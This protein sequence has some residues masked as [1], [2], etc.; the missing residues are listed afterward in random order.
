MSILI[1][2]P[3]AEPTKELLLTQLASRIKNNVP[4]IYQT[5][6]NLQ[7]QGIDSVWSHQTFT[8][9]EIVDA[10]GADAVKIFQ[11]HGK[12]TSLIEEIASAENITPD[13]K[14]PKNAFTVDPT[15]GK[16]TISGQPYQK[17]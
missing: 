3:Q 10:L 12:L 2:Q 1:N 15:T 11:Y 7:K 17:L 8:P 13:I 14:Y 4:S 5:L 9:Q 16:I 6:T